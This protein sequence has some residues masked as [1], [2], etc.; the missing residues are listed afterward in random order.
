MA[1]YREAIDN[2][3]PH[4]FDPSM[5]LARPSALAQLASF[6]PEDK[7]ESDE[8]AKKYMVCNAV[9]YHRHYRS[10]DY[11]TLGFR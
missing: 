3:M 5:S 7:A 6:V 10:T 1:R 4:R 2:N 8:I 9:D 11:S